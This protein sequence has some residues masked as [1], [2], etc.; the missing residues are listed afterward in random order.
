MTSLLLRTFIKN[1]ENTGDVRIRSAYGKLAGTVGI[2]LNVLLFAFKLLA[3]TLTGSVSITADALNNLTDASSGIISLLGF[4]LA[5]KPADPEHPYGHARYEYLAGLSVAVIVLIIGVDLLE[6]AV[7][8]IF[9]PTDVT[10]RWLTVIILS[11]S[12]LVKIWL[13]FFNRRLGKAI[14]SE[15]LIATGADSRNDAIAT[16]AVLLS[17]LIARY[18]SVNLDGYMGAAVA[19]FILYSGIGLLR[20]TISPLLGRAPDPETVRSI[21][22]KILSYPGVLGMHDLI[23][24]DYGPGRQ[25]ASVH[26]EMAAEDDVLESHDVIDNIERDFL[27]EGLHLIVHYDPIAISDQATS[28]LREWLTAEVRTI[29]PGL[30]LH[31]LRTV[32]GPTHTNVIFDLVIPH[33]YA[34]EEKVIKEKIREAVAQR[35]PN[36][37][38]VIT[39]DHDFAGAQHQVNENE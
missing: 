2:I 23:L 39:V 6:S 7:G 19:L 25:F 37:F 26:V 1:H 11:V 4:K 12:I 16:S 38:C 33:E 22:E 10:F 13:A 32:P 20:E 5:A 28:E 31:D 35:Y 3:G 30:S 15:A 29:R 34:P 36:H 9:S 8:K 18:F 14:H 24:H 21:E 17:L 27:K